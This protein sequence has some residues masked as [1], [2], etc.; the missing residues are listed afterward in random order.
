MSKKCKKCQ[1]DLASNPIKQGED[2]YCSLECANLAAGY[3]TDEELSYFEEDELSKDLY[4][5]FED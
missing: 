2:F 3:E 1:D 4:N 5:D